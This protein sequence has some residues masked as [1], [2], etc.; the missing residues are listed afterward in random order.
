MLSYAYF[1]F[2]RKIQLNARYAVWF[3]P[4]L[5]LYFFSISDVHALGPKILVVGDSLSAEYGIARRS[6][7]VELLSLE[8]KSEII[9]PTQQ[10][11]LINASISGDTTSGG[12]NRL[13]ALLKRDHP[14][15][16]IIELGGND[17]LRGLSLATTQNNLDAMIKM[18]QLAK[19]KVLLLGMRIPP[20]YGRDYSEKFAAL[21]LELAKTNDCTLIPFFLAR[22]ATQ[23]E[24]FQSDGIHPTAQAQSLLMQE[25]KEA[26]LPLL[27]N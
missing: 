9:E 26:L 14:N 17:A 4:V 6:G 8:L 13:E 25:V 5:A 16:V 10:P 18:A 11:V 23:R 12:L 7:W 19:A 22:I 2:K 15:I 27:P 3:L 24:M 20:N 1:G 21:Y